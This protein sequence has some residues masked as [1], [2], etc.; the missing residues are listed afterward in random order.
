[1]VTGSAPQQDESALQP[2]PEVFCLAISPYRLL[3]AWR[4]SSE[5]FISI[6][7]ILSFL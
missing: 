6:Y 4:I 5:F 1:M 7:G 3:T 2:Q